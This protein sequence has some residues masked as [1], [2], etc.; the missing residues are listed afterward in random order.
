MTR[1]TTPNYWLTDGREHTM[2]PY[3][4]KQAKDLADTL[5]YRIVHA[6]EVA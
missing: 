2:G 6:R 1:T 3:T 4:W 5:G